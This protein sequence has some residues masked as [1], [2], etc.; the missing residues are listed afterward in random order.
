SF[1]KSLLELRKRNKALRAADPLSGTH[2]VATNSND[3]NLAFLRKRHDDEVLVILN[4]SADT[5][6]VQL[7]DNALTGHYRDIFTNEIFEVENEFPVEMESW[8]FR[9]FE[10]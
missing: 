6:E 5:I 9:V 7:N 10:K 8:D 1:Y 2:L 3:K 4:L